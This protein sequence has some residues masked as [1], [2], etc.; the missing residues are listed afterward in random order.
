MYGGDEEDVRHAQQRA[1]DLIE[2]LEQSMSDYRR[3]SEVRMIVGRVGQWQGVSGDLW[4]VLMRA[5][6]L[7]RES[8]GLFDVTAG[9]MVRLWRESVRSGRLPGD[10]ELRAAARRVGWRQIELDRA[11]A[12]VR[13]SSPGVEI[14]LGGIAKGYAAARARDE[15]AKLG[16]PRCLVALAG[17]V[18]AGEP[19][20]GEKGW[21]VGVS[22]GRRTIGVIC[23]K[24]MSVSTSGDSEQGVEIGGVRYAHIIDLRTGLGSTGRV[25]ATAVSRDGAIADALAT[26]M[27][28]ADEPA[29]Q[30]LASHWPA[31]G[32]V[33]TEDGGGARVI[34]PARVIRWI[35][36]P[37]SGEGG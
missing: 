30:R 31:T 15:L 2:R 17:D 5:E 9:P 32:C 16:H 23:L 7:S 4:A 13:V 26:V 28:L 27:C 24:G 3:G 14:D 36:G 1:Y 6:E 33:V 34:D 35:E 8:D 21:R 29:R 19:P 22:T 12:R 10:D 18:A 20:P 37:W 25:A 11:S